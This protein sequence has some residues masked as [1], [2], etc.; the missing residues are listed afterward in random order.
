M[1]HDARG[2]DGHDFLED[3]ADGQRDDVGALQERELGRCHAEGENAGEEQEEDRGRRA[4]GLCEHV[5]AGDHARGA[6]GEESDDG[7]GD[8]HDGGE[9]EER[10]ERIARGRVSEEEDLRQGPAEAAEEGARDHEHKADGVEG[11]FT[12]HHHDHAGGHG[13]DDQDQFPGRG[14]QAE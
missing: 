2:G 13:G 14:L 4:F 8:E 5:Q 9:E 11:R 1:E 12:R 7:E 3:A 6:F 10:R